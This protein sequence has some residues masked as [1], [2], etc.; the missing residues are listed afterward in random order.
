MSCS[1]GLVMIIK[2]EEAVVERALRS[3]L[4]FVTSYVIVDTG[5]TDRTKE[6]IRHVM[7]DLP[8]LLVDRPWVSFGHNRSEAL[9]LCDN[10]MDWAIMLDADDNLEGTVP[11]PE[12]W[13]TPVDALA[14]Q[15]R[16]GS[17]IHQRPQIFRTNIGWGYEGVVHEYAKCRSKERPLIGLLPP[18]TYMVTRCEGARSR[19]PNKYSND[20]IMLE[21]ALAQD[22]NNSRTL[23]Y[24]GQ[25]YRDA[26]NTEKA[27]LNYRRYLD[28]SGGWD[29]ERYTV[30]VNLIIIIDPADQAE[31][32]RLTWAA[33]E[34]CPDRIDAQYAYLRQ[35]RGLGLPLT[36][37]CYAIAKLVTNRKIGPMHMFAISAIYEWGLDD[38]LAVV[39]FATGRYR[40]AYEASMRCAM[41]APELS[42]RENALKNAKAAFD[43][44]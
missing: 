27:I 32:L 35:R 16:H 13:A 42:M 6:I 43:L 26:G 40:E 30:L 29:Q 12:I 28:L 31:K 4:P 34:L 10:R 18:E 36:Q 22:P 8:G 11:P 23:F 33:I 44:L 21:S 3:A 20:A 15:I 7:A 17:V 9:A 38:E 5:S 14:V 2:D 41:T 1:V 19:D 24:L 37:Q 39:A 25:S